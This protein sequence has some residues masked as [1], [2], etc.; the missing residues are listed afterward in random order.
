MSSIIEPGVYRRTRDGK[1]DSIQFDLNSASDTQG[2]GVN[3]MPAAPVD[4][5]GGPKSLVITK[6]AFKR[7]YEQ[8]KG[9]L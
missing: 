2:N 8:I 7:I 5:T 4:D 6:G 3:L 9:E 1:L